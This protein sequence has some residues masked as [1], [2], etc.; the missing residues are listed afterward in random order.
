[1]FYKN[2]VKKFTSNQK[3]RD[4]VVSDL[5][6][7]YEDF[8]KKLD[9]V[10]FDKT[11]DRVFSVGDLCD[12]GPDSL[13]C[14]GLI[15]EDW[16]HAVR[17]NHEWLWCRAH[18]EFH[19][20]GLVDS[21]LGDYHIFMSNGGGLIDDKQ[22]AVSLIKKLSD[23]PLCMEIGTRNGTAGVI[24]AEPPTND[25]NDLYEVH[26]KDYEDYEDILLWGRSLCMYKPIPHIDYTVK[27]IDTVYM[28]HTL[29]ERPMAVANRVYMETGGFLKYMEN[30][31]RNKYKFKDYLKE[32]TLQE[33]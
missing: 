23:L 11:I 7:C 33:I 15:D 24:H 12:R 2:L 6:G 22:L 31:T 9:R 30:V 1:M 20:L 14:M 13:S 16:F 3:G 19:K 8:I 5:H 28:G 32:L 21:T 29:V 18:N 25:W 27:N 26:P 4:F 17:G 10:D